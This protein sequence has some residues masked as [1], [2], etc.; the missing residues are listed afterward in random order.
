MKDP[1][2]RRQL[3]PDERSLL[4]YLLY[5]ILEALISIYI[6]IH[7]LG[8]GQITNSTPRAAHSAPAVISILWLRV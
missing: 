4:N 5:V 2:L 1:Y 3:T 6:V 7:N 8:V